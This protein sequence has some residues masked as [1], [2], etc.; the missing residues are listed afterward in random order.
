MGQVTKPNLALTTALVVHLL[1]EV[2]NEITRAMNRTAKFDLV[3]FGSYVVI[4]YIISLRGS[5][6]LMIDLA[7]INCELGPNRNF[8]MIGLKERVKGESVD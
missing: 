2:R 6:G 8:C 1:K 5:K 3:I 7:V 4:S